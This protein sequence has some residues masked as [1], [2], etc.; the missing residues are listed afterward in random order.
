M[1]A[2]ISALPSEG[3][4]TDPC[5]DKP[6]RHTMQGNHMD[7]MTPAQAYAY[8]VRT[9]QDY[10]R[11]L[12]YTIERKQP[13]RS[14]PAQPPSLPLSSVNTSAKRG[15]L[16]A[17]R[18]YA[19]ATSSKSSSSLPSSNSPC[20]S[21]QPTDKPSPVAPSVPESR[22]LSRSQH[23]HRS[24][25][26][27]PP[28]FDPN[29]PHAAAQG[30]SVADLY[31]SSLPRGD[32]HWL[33][34]QRSG[35]ASLAAVGSRAEP[36]PLSAPPMHAPTPLVAYPRFQASV[37]QTQL[38]QRSEL[39]SPPVS[40]AGFPSGRLKHNLSAHD[41]NLS[42]VNSPPSFRG[43]PSLQAPSAVPVPTVHIMSPPRSTTPLSNIAPTSR[44][45]R[46]IG[47]TRNASPS[48]TLPLE[49]SL[50]QETTSAVEED[51]PSMDDLPPPP[52]FEPAA[53]SVPSLL[54]I[55]SP[56]S[57]SPS[58]SQRPSSVSPYQQ[59]DL[60]SYTPS[61]HVTSSSLPF[62]DEKSATSRLPYRFTA[63]PHAEPA[64]DRH[65]SPAVPTPSQPPRGAAQSHDN[66]ILTSPPST[67]RSP[68]P[69]SPPRSTENLPAV[70]NSPLPHSETSKPPLI[71][72][73]PE[74]TEHPAKLPSEER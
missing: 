11:T 22:P 29:V 19:S 18:L 66:I 33:R 60:P 54:G 28:A 36:A 3:Q 47:R 7:T 53:S 35:P 71:L 58:S 51:C 34:A 17:Q 38:T 45:A 64:V 1:Y 4:G 50:L 63:S 43:T 41:I 57:S 69:P 24:S 27:S 74:P 16:Y 52:P 31:H 39:S 37:S 21:T 48:F 62:G 44:S 14:P 72:R 2:S 67:L 59:A 8:A 5:Q 55:S 65:V 10:N 32:L 40:L 73:T 42:S 70:K 68:S 25:S 30:F 20:V 26:R 49:R 46:S 23:N 6:A 61:V 56:M 12:H 13:L 15:G 9:G